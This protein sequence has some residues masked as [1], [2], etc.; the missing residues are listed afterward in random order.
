MNRCRTNFGDFDSVVRDESAIQSR[1]NSMLWTVDKPYVVAVES[2]NNE[3]GSP[4]RVSF[5]IA[6]TAILYTEG[7][8]KVSSRPGS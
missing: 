7:S 1:S 4:T 6:D 3:I 5:T 2:Q 8:K